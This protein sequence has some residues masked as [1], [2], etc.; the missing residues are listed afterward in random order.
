M[1]KRP[2]G[3]GG[4]DKR[5]KNS[6]RLRYW[7]DDKQYSV[8]F[9]GTRDEAQKELRSILRS[10]DTGEHATPTKDTLAEWAKQWIEAGAPGR[11]RVAPGQRAR[12]R[13]DQLLRT[14]VLPTLG[15]YKLQAIHST[16]IDK[17]YLSLEGKVAPA[18]AR[19][20]HN[21]LGACLGAAVRTRKLT[22]NPM[23]HVTKVPAKGESDHGIALDDQELKKLVQGFKGSALFGIVSVAAFTGARR[24]E[25]LAL[26]WSDFDAQEKTLRIEA[27][28][29]GNRQAWPPLQGT[30]ERAPQA[31]Y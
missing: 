28:G 14:H 15:E 26:R 6:F 4:I 13:Y 10:I 9:R 19:A 2:H 8:T 1:T 21:T 11:K 24:G 18:T 29:R 17:L 25:I 16:N 31:D 27:L 12:E 3:T 5:G 7:K 20:I 30:E 23:Q 22:I